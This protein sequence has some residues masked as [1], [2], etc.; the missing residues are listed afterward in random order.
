[1]FRL[2]DFESSIDS[3]SNLFTLIIHLS[4]ILFMVFTIQWK[5]KNPYF[6]EVELWEAIPTVKEQAK[7]P[8][9]AKANPVQKIEIEKTPTKPLEK[10]QDDQAEINLKQKKAKEIAEQKKKEQIKKVQQELLKQE[11]IKQLQA[12]PTSF[13]FS[14]YPVGPAG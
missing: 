2:T 13:N 14:A 12:H 5:P 9:K 8:P 10:N 3:Q 7:A 4:L 11:Q 6:A 1:M